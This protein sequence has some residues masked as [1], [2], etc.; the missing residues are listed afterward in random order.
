MKVFFILSK[1][2][3]RSYFLLHFFYFGHDPITQYW[4]YC[5]Y[6]QMKHEN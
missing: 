5:V 1:T 6:L 2:K 4:L 3:L